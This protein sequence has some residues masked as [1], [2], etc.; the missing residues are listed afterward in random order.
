MWVYILR[1]SKTGKTFAFGPHAEYPQ[2]LNV[3]AQVAARM[4][5][6]EVNVG[7]FEGTHVELLD[8]GAEDDLLPVVEA[9]QNAQCEFCLEPAHEVSADDSWRGFYATKPDWWNCP[10]EP[11]C[12]ECGV[13]TDDANNWCGTCGNCTEH[14]E[15]AEEDRGWTYPEEYAEDEGPD[16]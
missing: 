5:H 3:A 15:C 2:S 12:D 16:L 14:C 8:G 13:H 9:I 10:Y 6:D 7:R 4:T 1:D 11:R